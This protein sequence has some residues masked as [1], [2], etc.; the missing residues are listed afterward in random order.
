MKWTENYEIR[1]HDTHSNEIVGI[2][3]IFKLLQESAMRQMRDCRPSYQDL[4]N[5]GKALILSSMRVE[6]YSP[7]YPYENISVKT[8]AGNNNKGFS[9]IRSY[10]MYRGEELIGESASA[11]A[12]VSIADKKLLRI[13][14]VDFTNYEGEEPLVL[15]GPMRVR[16]PSEVKM[17][18][19]G[20]YT[21][22][23]SD[24]DIN[25]HMNNTNYPDMI[26][27]CLPKPENKLVKS[28]SITYLKE[29][30]IGDNLKIYMAY[31]DG[32]YFFRSIHEDGSV[33]VEGEIIVENIN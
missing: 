2:S 15:E 26:F 3:N 25:N 9:T 32:K 16:I 13:S 21:V 23:Y 29:A 6:M 12:L 27:N 28:I 8:W 5:Q 31:T 19:V 18:L 14:E 24:I 10:Q 22:R 17:N 30:K 20:E 4:V 7:V 1:Y 33:N 11:W